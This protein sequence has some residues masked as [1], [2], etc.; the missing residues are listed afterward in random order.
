MGIQGARTPLGLPIAWW[1]AL[2]TALGLALGFS[3]VASTVF[4]QFVPALSSAF[5][6]TRAET[7]LAI[8]FANVPLL[9]M[10]PAFGILI[11]RLGAWRTLC[12]SQI[13]VPL[14][15]MSLA[16]LQGSLTQLYVSFFLLSLLGAGTL[17]AAYTRIILTWFDRRRGI[18]F[19]IALSGVGLAAL[20][21]PPVTQ[22]LIQAVGWRAS[23]IVIGLF[24]LVAG[25][26]NAMTLMRIKPGSAA[27][28][29]AGAVLAAHPTIDPASGLDWREALRGSR[30]WLIALAYIP[31]G[32]A[33]M[34]LLVNL[35]ALLIDRGFSVGGF[36]TMT[37]VLGATLIFARLVTGWM[38][39]RLRTVHVVA[40][41]FTAPSIGLFLLAEAH[42]AELTAAAVFLIAFGIGAEFDVMA[43]LL[44]RFFGPVSYGRLYGGV[45][46]SYNIG[47]AVGPVYLAHQFDLTGAYGPTLMLFALLFAVAGCVLTAVSR[48]LRPC[49]SP[50]P[51]HR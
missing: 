38:L 34:G 48:P 30:Y 22:I 1:V 31:L 15:L 4:G 3:A 11:D 14:I 51:C 41:I 13:A 18:G 47:V 42:S 46:A 50:E 44:S 17:P 29:D 40:L 33:S 5:G 37:A 32:A 19:G 39:D 7:T 25:T 35:P 43:F 21:F 20:V 23:I 36:A 24:F 6:W 10:A 26:L 8:T 49:Q 28:I 27:E 45:Y 12:V 2:G 16:T 9:I